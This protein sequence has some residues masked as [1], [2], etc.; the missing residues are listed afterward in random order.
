MMRDELLLGVGVCC[1][2]RM[3]CN[4]ERKL[5]GIGKHRAPESAIQFSVASSETLATNRKGLLGR[6]ASEADVQACRWRGAATLDRAAAA[7][8]V[9]A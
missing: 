8:K 4:R 5:G 6:E 7:P 2:E 3:D 1:E 9:I